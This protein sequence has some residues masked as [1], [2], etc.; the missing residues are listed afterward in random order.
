MSF[1]VLKA[2]YWL[3]TTGFTDY[4]NNYGIKTAHIYCLK[5]SSFRLARCLG[6]TISY[7]AAIQM[8]RGLGS[9]LQSCTVEITTS[10]LTWLLAEFSF[11]QNVGLGAPQSFIVIGSLLC[12]PL[13]YDFWLHG[14]QKGRK[15]SSK[16]AVT[17]LC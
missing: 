13:Q 4:C 11:L 14:S 16:L 6:L 1:V 2:R 7:K 12:G 5:V 9:H 17:I 10:K 8:S 15:S 3:F